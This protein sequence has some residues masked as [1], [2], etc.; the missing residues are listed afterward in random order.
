MPTIGNRKSNK[1]VGRGYSSDPISAFA[2]KYRDV[3]HNIMTESGIDIFSE[4]TKTMVIPHACEALKDFFVEGVAEYYAGEVEAQLMTNEQLQEAVNDAEE[5]FLND[6]EAILEHSALGTYNPVIGM[7]FPIHKTIMMNNVFDKG[8]IP[9][10]VA[11]EPKFT[12]SLETRLLIT[13]DGQEIDM[14][15]EQYKMT[16]AI[17][18]TAPFKEV[19]VTLPE[20]EGTTDVLTAIGGTSDDNLSI[21]THISAVK[22]NAY[23]KDGDRH[24]DGTIHDSGDGAID[25]WFPVDM[26]FTPGYG[27]FDRQIMQNFKAEVRDSDNPENFKTIQ[28]AVTGYTRKNKFA[29]NNLNGII[30]A[31]KIKGRIDTSTAMVETCSVSWK[32]RTDIIEIPEAIPINTTVSPEE[33]KDIGALYQVNQLSKILSLLKSALGNYKDDMIKMGLD[34]SY[35]ALPNE[36]KFAE[37]FDFAPRAGYAFDHLEWRYKTFMDALDTHVTVL[38]QVLNDPNMTI[39]VFGRPD[40]IRKITPT[41]YTYQTPSNVAPVELDFV[42]TVVTSDKR[43]YQFIGSDKLRDNNNLIVVL[44]PRN[45]ERF[46]Y[47]IYDYQMYVSNEIR[48]MK[49]YAL[50]AIH[51]FE[52]WVFKE[53]QPVQGRLLII[54]PTGQRVRIENTDPIGT[55]NYNDFTANLPYNPSGYNEDGSHK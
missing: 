7:T 29:L 15:K 21:A 23:F 47:R 49:N 42:K 18:A 46:V 14:W 51:A 32:V 36:C 17:N 54:N 52:R 20:I 37:T 28:D 30:K 2:G 10:V 11:R 40:L 39:S 55:S 34:D 9:K 33:V 25:V 41:E 1:N 12:I 50:P 27:E 22:V 48:N 38:L 5:Q 13:K 45:T 24:P 8:A 31:V 16:D 43:V 44:N 53:Y 4:P 19:E 26:V 3:A 35:R 6:R